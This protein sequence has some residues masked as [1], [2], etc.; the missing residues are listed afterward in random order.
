MIVVGTTAKV[1][2]WWPKSLTSTLK[3][4]PRRP[5]R[6]LT[7]PHPPQGGSIPQ[8]LSSC[9]SWI[10]DAAMMDGLTESRMQMDLVLLYTGCWLRGWTLL[11]MVFFQR[12]ARRR[13]FRAPGIV[14]IRSPVPFPKTSAHIVGNFC[15]KY[16]RVGGASDLCVKIFWYNLWPVL[17]YLLLQICAIIR[18]TKCNGLDDNEHYF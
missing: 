1:D 2:H 13:C 10:V 9:A 18:W 14:K 16:P 11:M 15:Q 12:T 5:R 3:P 8:V 6:I 17:V 4:A 7:R